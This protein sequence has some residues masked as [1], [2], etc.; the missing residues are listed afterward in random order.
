[1]KQTQKLKIS[2]SKRLQKLLERLADQ[3]H[4]ARRLQD[5]EQRL[6]LT[7]GVSSRDGP[8]DRSSSPPRSYAA[9]RSRREGIG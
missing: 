9:L 4:L 1:M 7:R 6:E 8:P 2:L 5:L 3:N